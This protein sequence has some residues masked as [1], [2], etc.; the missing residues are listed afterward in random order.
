MKA[1]AVLTGDGHEIRSRAADMVPLLTS[2]ADALSDMELCMVYTGPVPDRFPEWPT[3]LSRVH[4]I[5]LPDAGV[6]DPLLDFISDMAETC[7]KNLYL[8][9]GTDIG[10]C[11]AARLGY[12]LAGSS[13][14]QVQTCRITEEKKLTSGRLACGGHLLA[15]TVLEKIPWCLSAAAT[16]G[17]ALGWT[18]DPGCPVTDHPATAMPVKPWVISSVSVPVET[19]SPLTGADRILVLGNGVGS[20]ETLARMNP[21]AEAL[22]AQIGATRPVV[23]NGW[24]PMARLI[25]VSGTMVAPSLCIVA[26]ASGTGAFCAGIRQAECIVAIN[27]DPEAPVFE[28]A[29]VGIVDDLVPVLLALE[30]LIRKKESS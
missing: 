13:C 15:R 28:T 21:V 3:A 24:L 1:L 6:P 4:R 9:D 29:D 2:L 8:F 23:M 22:G 27:T 10:D 20:R 25:G 16:P 19:D 26:G 12:R 7:P 14:L 18:G 5:P 30:V 17:A 11:L